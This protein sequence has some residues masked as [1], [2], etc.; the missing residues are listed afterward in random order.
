MLSRMDCILVTTPNSA[1]WSSG[2]GVSTCARLSSACGETRRVQNGRNKVWTGLQQNTYRVERRLLGG[3]S[4]GLHPGERALAQHD[5]ERMPWYASRH[6][7]R[8]DHRA[9]QWRR[10][11]VHTHASAVAN[12]RE[13][14]C[15]ARG[16]GTTRIS[17]TRR[18]FGY[19]GEAN[20][21]TTRQQTGR[22][23][24]VTFEANDGTL[25]DTPRVPAV[26]DIAS[27]N[28]I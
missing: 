1:E 9:G 22:Q 23:D 28:R 14:G 3:V 11:S 10:K 7:R 17:R 13:G 16:S 20:E 2:P 26:T 15:V 12:H 25:T 8:D 6:E 18:E 21:R 4:S 24:G 27:W 5:V 19:G